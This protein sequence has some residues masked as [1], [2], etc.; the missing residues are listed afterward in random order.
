MVQIRS[1]VV[2]QGGSGLPEDQFVNVFHFVTAGSSYETDSAAIATALTARYQAIQAYF[3]LYVKP[4]ATI[5]TYNMADAEP[6]EPTIYPLA[7]TIQAATISLPNEVALCLSYEGDPPHTARRRGRIYLG[8]FNTTAGQPATA[9]VPGR[10]SSG[11]VTQ[12]A[13]FGL[14]LRAAN[15]GWMVWSP[16]DEVYVPIEQ[17][18]VDNEWDTMRKRGNEATSR[19]LWS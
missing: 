19:T 17:G 2:L 4:A 14:N 10:P 5:K 11:F 16:T 7:L 15:L 9:T 8:P 6:R 1:Q 3:S 12:I 13:N 18:W